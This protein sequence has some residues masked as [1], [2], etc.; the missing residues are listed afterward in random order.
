MRF[1]S[2]Q[3]ASAFGLFRAR[4]LGWLRGVLLFLLIQPLESPE[5]GERAGDQ[6]DG[7]AG[8]LVSG[9][10]VR[11]AGEDRGLRLSRWRRLGAPV[12]GRA[13]LFG[14]WRW[15]PEARD[16]FRYMGALLLHEQ[17]KLLD[18]GVADAVLGREGQMMSALGPMGRCTADG[19]RVVVLASNVD[20][21]GNPSGDGQLGLR[22]AIHHNLEVAFLP[23]HTGGV[24]R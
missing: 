17:R 13:G 3:P 24:G 15:A 2:L 14:A 10:R 12:R 1:D 23:H 19:G 22:P 11:S 16:E 7:G 8:I 21:S 5:S 18:G 4:L 9:G 20:A 6:G